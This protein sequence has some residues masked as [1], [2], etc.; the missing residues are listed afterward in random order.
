MS[1]SGLSRSLPSCRRRHILAALKAKIRA[2][3][4]DLSGEARADLE[5]ALA[6]VKDGEVKA[7]T[8]LASFRQHLDE[9]IADTEP[10]LKTALTALATQLEAELGSFLGSA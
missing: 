2:Y 10:G 8:S 1:S 7:R 6:D 5:Q 9:L 4:H 3:W